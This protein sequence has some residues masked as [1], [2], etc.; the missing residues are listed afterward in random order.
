[1]NINGHNPNIDGLR[2]IA[3]LMVLSYHY[4]SGFYLFDFGWMGV[5]L[6]FVLSGYLLTGRFYPYVS[7]KKIILNFYRNRFLRIVPLIT[8]FLILFY[9]SFYIF[10]SQDTIQNLST[11]FDNKTA[12]FLFLTNWVL[13]FYS[14]GTAGPLEHLWSL[15]VEEQ[16]YLMFPIFVFLFKSRKKLL[17]AGLGFILLIFIARIIIYSNHPPSADWDKRIYWNTFLRADSFLCGFVLYMLIENGWLLLIKKYAFKVS[18]AATLLLVL[19]CSYYGT[20]K[21]NPFLMRGGLLL[22]AIVGMC[23]LLFSITENKGFV[24]KITGFQKLQHLGKISYGLYIF[25]WPIFL[26]GFSFIQMISKKI[27]LQL[28]ANML[29]FLN[30]IISCITTYII[31]KLSFMY[32]ESYFLAKKV[33][34]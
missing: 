5:D 3:I 26:F 19:G 32:F 11:Y 4:F 15:A 8:V 17:I 22:V 33:K 28:T 24:K 29:Q 31:S 20:A 7:T 14:T 21:L 25:H 18:L 9:L 1:M 13:F 12:I 23:L 16:F 10:A 27:G 2:G 34:I 6:F 30:I